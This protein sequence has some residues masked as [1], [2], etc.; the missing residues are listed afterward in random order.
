MRVNSRK[1]ISLARLANQTSQVAHP[2]ASK[3]NHL[4]LLI[5]KLNID[6]V[7]TS[8]VPQ[9]LASKSKEGVEPDKVLRRLF[10]V[11][12]LSGEQQ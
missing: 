1:R 11:N 12:Y 5:V 9:P 6:K 3:S 4:L 2:I 10:I 8:Q 7:L